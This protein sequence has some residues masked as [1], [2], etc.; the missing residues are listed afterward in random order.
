VDILNKDQLLALE[1]KCI[2]EEPPAAM[3]ACPLKVECRT[4]CMAVKDGHFDAARASY[5]RLVPL[6]H[7]LS[8]LCR[9]PCTEACVRK[10]LGGSLQMRELE[11]AAMACGKERPK[12]LRPVRK[13]IGRAH[14]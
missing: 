2:Q 11:W 8:H 10:D 13:K 12:P 5:T 4:I 1:E 3:A 7:A 9:M 6:P 14:V